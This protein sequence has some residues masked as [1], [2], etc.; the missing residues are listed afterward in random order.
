MASA[1]RMVQLCQHCQLGK[2]GTTPNRRAKQS[3]H[4]SRVA[5]KVDEFRGYPSHP[6]ELKKDIW[7]G[8]E[9]CWSKSREYQYLK[10]SQDDI[11]NQC[12]EVCRPW[13]NGEGATLGPERSKVRVL[14]AWSCE[15]RRYLFCCFMLCSKMDS[16]TFFL[17]LH[18][19]T[20]TFQKFQDHLVWI[21]LT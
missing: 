18:V 17:E 5:H 1:L 10:T 3:F 13:H 2:V 20:I 7:S 14:L 8:S 21:M 9:Q 6:K 4:C 15:V 19:R 16:K 12:A 11:K